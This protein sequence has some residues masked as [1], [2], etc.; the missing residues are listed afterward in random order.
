MLKK[1][2][3]V[4]VV[5]GCSGRKDNSNRIEP[6]ENEFGKL[7][8]SVPQNTPFYFVKLIKSVPEEKIPFYFDATAED[9][10]K[11]IDYP[12]SLIDKTTPN[13]NFSHDREFFSNKNIRSIRDGD[14]YDLTRSKIRLFRRLP[15]DT[16][17]YY[18]L[19]AVDKPP[20]ILWWQILIFNKKNG[21]QL[22]AIEGLHGLYVKRDTLVTWWTFASDPQPDFMVW[23]KKDSLFEMKS[24]EQKVPKFLEKVVDKSGQLIR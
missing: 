9:S 14:K 18:V 8:K 7:I 16:S 12:D 20:S 13:K 15:I 4:I 17:F 6:D 2:F 23:L 3:I 1:L 22:A 24:Q 11:F 5:F 10:L 21:E 19:G